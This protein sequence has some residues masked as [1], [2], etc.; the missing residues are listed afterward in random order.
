ML[1]A[2]GLRPVRRPFGVVVRVVPRPEVCPVA[3]GGGVAAGRRRDGFSDSRN[4]DVTR[5]PCRSYAR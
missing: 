5:V 3:A 4:Q 2:Y 1:R